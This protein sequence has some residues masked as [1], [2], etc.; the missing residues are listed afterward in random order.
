MSR[1][2]GGRRATG[3]AA[4]A[5]LAALAACAGLCAC[6]S[7]AS[8]GSDPPAII[9]A[10]AASS[11]AAQVAVSPEPGT[12]DASPAT[13]ISFLGPK[14]TTVSSVHVVGSHSHSHAGVLRAYSTGTGESFLPRHPF[15]PG[16][17]VSVSAQV[18]AGG[19]AFTVRTSFTVAHQASVTQ[20]EFPLEAG[21]PHDV[22]HFSTAPSLTPSSV[23]VTTPARA[24]AAG[25]DLFLA[26]YQGLGTP[27]EMI[28]EQDGQL[29]WFRPLPKGEESTNFRVQEYEGKPVLTWWQGRILE[30][31]F[32]Q[33]EDEIYDTSYRRVA[34]IRAG[35]GY[36][37]DLH[38]VRIT[39]EGTA[40]IDE[41][42]PIKLNLSRY[43]GLSDGVL[44]DSIVQ[45]IDI[46]TGLVMWEWHALGHIPLSESHNA[47]PRTPY[48]W[49]AYH[50]NSIS[51]GSEGDL[52]LSSRNT[53]TLYDVSL[54]GGAVRWRLGGSHSS[55]K[56]GPGTRTYWQHDAEWQPGG[57]ISVF[58][59]GSYP[60]E[61]KQSR[62][63]VLDPNLHTKTVTLVKAL[64]NPAKTLLASSQGDMLALPGGDWMMGY[65]GL[66]NFTEYSSSGRVL[67]DGTLGKGV[68][69]FRTYLSPWSGQPP[70]APSVRAAPGSS[71]TIAVSV[72]WNGATEV[73]SWRVLAGSSPSSLA[74]AAT[75]AKQGFQTTVS[76]PGAG[77]Y[78]Q[79][80]ALSS[81][82]AVLGTSPA[83]K[84]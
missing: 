73:T 56:L 22:Q 13:Q 41:F 61:E 36:H 75:A 1:L 34:T 70:G 24:G 72:S 43:H 48:P 3:R 74:A 42:D 84:D 6:G 69:D 82:G 59:N 40:W 51:P 10:G 66:P 30:V 15:T 68:Q 8:A 83:V 16:E 27:G 50:V 2:G 54:H 53:W 64:T 49:D 39:P 18:K 19:G 28:A 80:Q 55:F 52:L 60:P 26:P 14:G 44:S 23:Q 17:H 78:V 71:G 65:G 45:E 9:T 4:T 76:V 7:G 38:E 12:P 47:A 5:P 67:L 32:G 20:K 77:P 81:S 11:A 29:V 35:N 46:K 37:A 25:G 79:V 58:D 57:L 31:G 63:L 21:N 62:G 33:G